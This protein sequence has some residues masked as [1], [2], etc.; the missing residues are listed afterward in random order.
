MST[1]QE[2]EAKIA[3]ALPAFRGISRALEQYLNAGVGFTV[4]RTVC[5]RRARKLRKRGEVVYFIGQTRNG[6]A[7][8]EYRMLLTRIWK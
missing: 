1:A 2:I 7:R 5:A 8:Y 6:K 3:A 4:G